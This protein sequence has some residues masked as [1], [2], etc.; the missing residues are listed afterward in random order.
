MAGSVGTRHDS[1]RLSRSVQL[2]ALAAGR[3]LIRAIVMD[4]GPR[5]RSGALT[6]KARRSR[7]F[8]SWSAKPVAMGSWSR[9]GY[10]K[11]RAQPTADQDSPL[12]YPRVGQGTAHCSKLRDPQG[13][14]LLRH[15]RDDGL[16]RSVR[17]ELASSQATTYNASTTFWICPSS[18]GRTNQELVSSLSLRRQQFYRGHTRAADKSIRDTVFTGSST[19][20]ARIVERELSG[21]ASITVVHRKS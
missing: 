8:A 15:P 2:F 5:S 10:L 20:V 6:A 12:V 3:S 7:R 9:S 14:A 18:L 11:G 17:A 21:P 16:L 1:P 4:S 13:Y 19:F